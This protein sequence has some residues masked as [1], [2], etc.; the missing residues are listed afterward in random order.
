ML[1]VFHGTDT[2]SAVT[3]ATTLVSSLRTKRPDASYVRVE[4]GQ[5]N[6]SIIEEH[7][8][9]QGLFSNKYI[10][11]LDRVTENA[12]A[13][14]S[15]AGFVP[16]MAESTNIFIVL[17]GKLNAELKK[18]LEKS[19]EKMVECGDSQKSAVD[20]RQSGDFNIFA[21]ADAVGARD[22][23]KAWSVYREAVDQGNE[24]E[25]IIGTLFWQVKSMK[26]AANAKSAGESGL[27]PFVFSKAKKAAGNYSEGELDTLTEKLITVYHDAHRGVCDA[28]LAVER[29]MLDLKK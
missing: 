28:E 17:E 4:A 18:A 9:G 23:F 22:P 14:E 25:S 21:L 2:A 19:A 12:E 10:I 5:W 8:G 3:K 29:V 15:F 16:V 6:P 7:I 24:P 13:K 1:Y 20:S 11:Y 26:L 27:S